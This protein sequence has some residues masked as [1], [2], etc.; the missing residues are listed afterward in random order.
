MEEW[1]ESWAGVSE[2]QSA[3]WVTG[4]LDPPYFPGLDIILAGFVPP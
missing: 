2:F 4:L 1:E 3:V